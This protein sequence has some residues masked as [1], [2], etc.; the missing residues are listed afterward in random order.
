MIN[1]LPLLSL[2][3]K[4]KLSLEGCHKTTC[5]KYGKRRHG[6]SWEWFKI[7]ANYREDKK[8]GGGGGGGEGGRTA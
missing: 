1:H 5:T 2:L 8:Q 4:S 7:Q 3:I 6:E